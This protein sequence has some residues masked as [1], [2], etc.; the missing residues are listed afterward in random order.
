[1]FHNICEEHRHKQHYADLIEYLCERCHER[2]VSSFLYHREADRDENGADEV[3]NECVGSH[4]LKIATELCRNHGS[5]GS[6]RP[7]DAREKRFY[8][9]LVVAR[10]I[11]THDDTHKSG[12]ENHLEY[13]Y[14]E[15]PRYGT[16][17]SEIHF[18]ECDK[19]NAKHE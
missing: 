10:K 3:G 6:A 8:E 16:Q 1:M 2:D 7:D 11:K 12:Y 4:F 14:P 18:A 5:S 17:L 13:A 15:M 9:N 19:E